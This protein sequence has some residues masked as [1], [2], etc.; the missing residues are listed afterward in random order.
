MANDVKEAF[1]PIDTDV[2]ESEAR[3]KIEVARRRR[4][5]LT[6][7]FEVENNDETKSDRAG[8]VGGDSNNGIFGAD[9]FC[10]VGAPSV[11]SMATRTVGRGKLEAGGADKTNHDRDGQG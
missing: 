9:H 5:R 7:V 11:S 10:D 6:Y 8:L 3:F 4:V 2:I 1:A